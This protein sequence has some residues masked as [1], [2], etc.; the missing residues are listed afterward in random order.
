MIHQNDIESLYCYHLLTTLRHYSQEVV[1]RHLIVVKQKRRD[2][3]EEKVPPWD[4]FSCLYRA[5]INVARWETQLSVQIS[6]DEK[7]F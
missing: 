7:Y 2:E 4:S 3:R 5:D 1:V 6:R